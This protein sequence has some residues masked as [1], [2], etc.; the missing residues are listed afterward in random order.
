MLSLYCRTQTLYFVF[1]CSAK[2]L[3]DASDWSMYSNILN[4]IVLQNYSSVFFFQFA[5]HER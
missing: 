4:L 2:D 1:I 5:I 3:F